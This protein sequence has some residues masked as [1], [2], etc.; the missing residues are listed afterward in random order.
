MCCHR[1]IQRSHNTR[2]IAR[3]QPVDPLTIFR[4][5]S[6]RCCPDIRIVSIEKYAVYIVRHAFP[7]SAEPHALHRGSCSEGLKND[8]AVRS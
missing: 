6:D 5:H 7:Y 8:E 1:L 3:T 4:K 2:H